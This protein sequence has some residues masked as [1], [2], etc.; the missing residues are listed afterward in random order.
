[1]S[2]ASQNPNMLV[3][4]FPQFYSNHHPNTY[5]YAFLTK[6]W[7]RR[8]VRRKMNGSESKEIL[9]G[10][11]FNERTENIYHRARKSSR[12]GL[13]QRLISGYVWLLKQI[14]SESERVIRLRSSTTLG[15]FISFTFSYE[16]CFHSIICDSNQFWIGGA[17]WKLRKV[18]R[19]I[20]SYRF[21]HPVVKRQQECSINVK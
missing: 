1:M 3:V 9:K 19:L 8:Q 5:H 17:I 18:F 16:K 7:L 12:D 2:H 11:S 21:L 10:K 6:K 15:S 13:L 4:F 14:L 20:I